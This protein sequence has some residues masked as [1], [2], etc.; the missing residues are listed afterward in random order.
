MSKGTLCL[1][2]VVYVAASSHFT[3][4]SLS[5]VCNGEGSF[6]T[7]SCCLPLASASPHCIF[8]TVGYRLL[9]LLQAP[10]LGWT[11]CCYNME[12]PHFL[13]LLCD[14]KPL[15]APAVKVV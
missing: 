1:P 12:I 5:E 11:P 14:L 13:L 10:V 9:E 8:S 4:Y 3:D 15:T 6:H 2:S 7:Y